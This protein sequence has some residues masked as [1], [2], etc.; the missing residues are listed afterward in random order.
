MIN[1]TNMIE[2]SLVV[3]IIIN[4]SLLTMNY[5]YYSPKE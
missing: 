5:H 2:S 1:I 3:N 4:I